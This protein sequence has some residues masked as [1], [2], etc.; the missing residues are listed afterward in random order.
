VYR[1]A[2]AITNPRQVVGPVPEGHPELA[3]AHAQAVRVLELRTPDQFVWAV[4]RAE[5]ERTVAAYERVHATAPREVSAE[6]RAERLA[7]ADAR[8]RA[9]ELHALGQAELAAQAEARADAGA[10]SAVELEGAAAAYATWE[11]ITAPHRAAAELAQAEVDRRGTTCP[12]LPASP[13]ELAA[14]EST[15]TAEPESQRAE[16]EG[17]DG[18]E[19]GREDLAVKATAGDLEAAVDQ[20]PELDTTSVSPAT[21]ARA[22]ELAARKAAQAEADA[23]EAQR[24]ANREAYAAAQLGAPEPEAP[25]AWAQGLATPEWGGPQSRTPAAEAEL[26]AGL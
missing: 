25:S 24:E 19:A 1:E 9:L 11:E 17:L 13:P 23:D 8:T 15:P 10:H 5:L 4:P 20:L 16:A 3:A 14:G 12:Q 26:E 22:A 21:E 7:E 18:P 2:A 6:L